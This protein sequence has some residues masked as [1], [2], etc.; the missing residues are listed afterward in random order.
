MHELTV[1]LNKV[2]KELQDKK[3]KNKPEERYKNN[4]V[5]DLKEKKNISKKEP[6]IYDTKDKGAEFKGEDS[7]AVKVKD[8]EPSE[9]ESQPVQGKQK[10]KLKCKMCN[11]KCKK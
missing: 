4:M 5:D 1:K 8:M 3:Q 6:I 2:E 9:E 7:V 11:Y 10:N